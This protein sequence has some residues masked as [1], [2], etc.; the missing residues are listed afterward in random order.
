VSDPQGYGMKTTI[1]ERRISAAAR[2][3]RAVRSVRSAHI[4]VGRSRW[5][6]TSS[7]AVLD[8]PRCPFRGGADWEP[9]EAAMRGRVRRLIEVGVLPLFAFGRLVAG[10]CRVAH[11]CIVC[12]GGIKI[13]EDEVEIA[14]PTGAVIVYLH[15]RCL[16]MRAYRERL[17]ADD[18]P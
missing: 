3:D 10:S 17:A 12:G 2:W 7:R 6:L 11:D 9:D 5:L 15:R 13:G 4:S 14:S 8:R 18:A 16:D 1:E